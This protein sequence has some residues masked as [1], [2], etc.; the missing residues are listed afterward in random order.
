MVIA[1]NIYTLIKLLIQV[2]KKYLKKQNIF[3]LVLK[4][5]T[6]LLISCSCCYSGT[7][8]RLVLLF[9]FSRQPVCELRR[10]TRHQ[11]S[12]LE[13]QSCR[14]QVLSSASGCSDCKIQSCDM[15]MCYEPASLQGCL[16][17]NKHNLL[18][19]QALY[20]CVHVWFVDSS[21]S[22]QPACQLS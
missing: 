22:Y 16:N 10:D 6:E 19:R 1:C 7:V 17:Y 14:P 8:D 5:Q 12:E 18:S 3:M 15:C 4:F 2:G 21:Y 20:L 13:H 11:S 9:L